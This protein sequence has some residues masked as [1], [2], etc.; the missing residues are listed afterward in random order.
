MPEIMTPLFGEISAT[1]P[2]TPVPAARVGSVARP[3]AARR[4]RPGPPAN[5]PSAPARDRNTPADPARSDLQPATA[6]PGPA[7]LPPFSQQPQHRAGPAT[8]RRADRAD[9]GD[10]EIHIGR[11]EVTAVSAPPAAPVA[12]AARK[13]INLS[14]YLRNGR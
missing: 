8:S 3:S 14:E 1:D 10:V 6:R 13:A 4:S 5:H 9:D 2:A 7:V 12:K 11:I